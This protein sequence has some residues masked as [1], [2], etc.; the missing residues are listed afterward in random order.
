L[1]PPRQ[2]SGSAAVQIGCSSYLAWAIAD[3]WDPQAIGARPLSFARFFAPP[4][5]V[6]GRRE[7]DTQVRACPP[8]RLRSSNPPQK[9]QEKP[10]VEV[11]RP[12]TGA[13][14]CWKYLFYP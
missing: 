3:L 7:K 8:H 6:Q 2:T 14:V 11:Q 10:A 9:K 5:G 13:K 12:M 1:L 4:A